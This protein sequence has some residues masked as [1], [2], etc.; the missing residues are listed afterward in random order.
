M[1]LL[2]IE[3]DIV[4]GWFDQCLKKVDGG[5]IVFVRDMPDVTCQPCILISEL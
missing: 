4:I 1:E 5:M 3:T 2:E